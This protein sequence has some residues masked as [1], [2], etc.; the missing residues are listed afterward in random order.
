MKRWW[1]CWFLAALSG[2]GGPESVAFLVNGFDLGRADSH[3]NNVVEGLN[4]DDRVSDRT[5]DATCRKRDY[6]SPG[7]DYE[8]GVDN[9]F[10]PLLSLAPRDPAAAIPNAIDRGDFS[11]SITVSELDDRTEY[12]AR[13]LGVDADR[14]R[15]A[16]RGQHETHGQELRTGDN[17]TAALPCRAQ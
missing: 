3:D 1:T 15:D 8:S 6:T 13:S 9:Q 2:C 11:L 5:D 4:L 12:G 14:R 10:G 17:V 16:R 7:P